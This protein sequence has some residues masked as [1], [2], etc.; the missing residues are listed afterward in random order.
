MEIWPL[1]AL[2]LGLGV[3]LKNLTP[4][5]SVDALSWPELMHREEPQSYFSA[6]RSSASFFKVNNQTLPKFAGKWWKSPEGSLFGES[7]SEVTP[8]GRQQTVWVEMWILITTEQD[9]SYIQHLPVSATLPSLPTLSLH[10]HPALSS[11]FLRQWWDP[12]PLPAHLPPCCCSLPFAGA[13]FLLLLTECVLQ[14]CNFT[15]HLLPRQ[16][17]GEFKVGKKSQKNSPKNSWISP[18]FCALPI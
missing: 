12:G 14:T 11:P 16:H 2:S 18:L 9:L 3:L 6:S 4:E 8:L 10:S 1:W 13:A 7:S 15:L 5:D 17:K